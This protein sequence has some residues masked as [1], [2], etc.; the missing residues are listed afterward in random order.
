MRTIRSFSSFCVLLSSQL[1]AQTTVSGGFM[2][3]G[4]QRD[5]LLY[6]PAIYDPAI[7]VPVV[8]NLHGYTSD[9]LQQLYY[10]DFRGIADTADFIIALPNGTIDP[11]GNRGWNTFG[12]TTVD[13]LGYITALL[14]TISAHYSVDPDRVYSTGMS[15]GGFMSYDLACF[16]SQRFAAIASVTGSML[17]SRFSSCA[18]THPVPV[19][20]VHG[21]ADPTVNYNG[22]SG[23]AG[24]EALVAYWAQQAHCDPSAQVTAVPNI[25][26]T[27]GCTAEH[28]LYSGGD[29]GSTVEFFK[30]LGG[31]H[32]WPDAIVDIGVT[33]HDF[34]ASREIWRFFRQY[35]L[36]ALTGIADHADGDVQFTAL[37]N[38]AYGPFLLQFTEVAMRTISLHDATGRQVLA[39][40]TAGTDV[41]LNPE[42]QGLYLLVVQQGGRTAVRRLV[43]Y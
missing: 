6:V 34:N 40:R 10:G 13:D 38:P 21:T 29:A 43:Q 1:L 30:V 4:V 3:G 19:M 27:D 11:L 16:R 12:A 5:Y 35:R 41:V 7:P 9:N 28:Y 42:G 15:N 22:G 25:N 33:N 36:G 26:A 2:H 18:A 14:D 8:F 24:I 23:I 31:G 39:L 37:P 32:T 20:Q 17:T